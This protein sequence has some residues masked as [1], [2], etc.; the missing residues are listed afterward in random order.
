M[1]PYT[2]KEIHTN[3]NVSRH[4]PLGEL[5]KL[6]GG[7][8]LLIVMI[9]FLLGVSVD[10]LIPH[11]S[12]AVEKQFEPI[13]HQYL[14]GMPFDSK[15]EKRVQKILD[16]LSVHYPSR[17]RDAFPFTL[18]V[19]NKNQLNAVSLPAGHI[20]LYSGLLDK[21]E[22]DN[23]VA[24]V[25]AHE[26][27]HFHNRDHLK[28]LGRG[29]VLMTAASVMLGSDNPFNDLLFKSVEI[30]ELQFSQQQE[31]SADLFAL[32]LVDNTYHH[33]EGAIQ[34]FELLAHHQS[35]DA[36]SSLLSTHPAPAQRLALMKATIEKEGLV[37]EAD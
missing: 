15:R 5:A 17:Q 26:L 12:P 3:V 7:S 14:S 30:T 10:L 27:G 24:F 29:L 9:Y 28:G 37:F 32:H 2:P 1:I 34:F 8:L 13:S 19:V 23:E 36:F 18:H 35:Y 6:L 11:I 22:S 21:L 25:I 20:V 4:S 33:V 31:K 16:Q